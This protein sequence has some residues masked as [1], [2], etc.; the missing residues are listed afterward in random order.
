MLFT[1]A[2]VGSIVWSFRRLKKPRSR[3]M[4]ARGYAFHSVC[5]QLSFSFPFHTA[6][7]VVHTF[8]TNFSGSQCGLTSFASSATPFSISS[9]SIVMEKCL[10]LD[11]S[12]VGY[13]RNPQIMK[14]M[15]KHGI[16]WKTSENRPIENW[17]EIGMC[18]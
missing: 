18:Y 8:K 3:E 4:G 6:I 17:I 5:P 10:G 15:E 14:I 1:Q 11:S 12:I 2:V 13:H 16:L 9:P 7:F